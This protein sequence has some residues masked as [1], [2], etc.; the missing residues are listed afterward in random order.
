MRQKKVDYISNRIG[1]LMDDASH[2]HRE[3]DKQWYMRI[4]Q[5]LS[6]AKQYT[7]QDFK[8]GCVLEEV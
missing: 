6:W 5:E 8:D 1:Q 3:E 7:Q 2:A 4:C